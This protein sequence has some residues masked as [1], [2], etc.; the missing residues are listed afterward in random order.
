MYNIQYDSIN[1]KT[2]LGNSGCM[3]VV[4]GL[5]GTLLGSLQKLTVKT[6]IWKAGHGI[7]YSTN[8]TTV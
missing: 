1:V 3:I 5:G 7:L 2:K 6:K 4:V 8:N